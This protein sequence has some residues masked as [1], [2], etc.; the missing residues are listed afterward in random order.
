LLLLFAAAN[1]L[2]LPAV[3]KPQRHV[4]AAGIPTP[5]STTSGVAMY[6]RRATAS[7]GGHASPHVQLTI[8]ADAPA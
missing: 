5:V 6:V 8:V 2:L 4:I 7:V 3:A 1:A